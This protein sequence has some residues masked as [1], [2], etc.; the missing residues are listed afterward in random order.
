MVNIGCFLDRFQHS[1][2]ISFMAMSV[3]PQN[4]QG[5]ILAT[6][7]DEAVLRIYDIRKSANGQL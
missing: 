2:R 3:Q 1:F 4:E 5:N 6:I 7:R